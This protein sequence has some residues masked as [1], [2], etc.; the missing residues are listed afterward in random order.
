M[1]KEEHCCWNH[2]QGRVHL[3][4]PYP[5]LDAPFQAQSGPDPLPDNPAP[6]QDNPAPLPSGPGLGP[7]AHVLP[8]HGGEGVDHRGGARGP[9]GA[10]PSEVGRVRAWGVGRVHRAWGE[11]P[12]DP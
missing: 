7:G 8:H 10:L 3:G 4:V 1:K 5:P 11:G 2:N 12:C 9:S 6:L